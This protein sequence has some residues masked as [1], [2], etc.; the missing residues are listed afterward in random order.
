MGLIVEIIFG[1]SF[2]LM[3]VTVV[4]HAKIFFKLKKGKSNLY[5]V[6]IKKLKKIKNNH[7][8]KEVI[9]KY[10]ISK[11]DIALCLYSRTT[12]FI[13]FAVAFI[14]YLIWVV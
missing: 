14:L 1:I 9:Q 7:T 4:Y 13:L 12:A 10:N 6:T 11:R 2:L 5:P 3:F 8:E